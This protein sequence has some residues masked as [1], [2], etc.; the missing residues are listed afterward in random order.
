[1]R[2]IWNFVWLVIDS[3]L[4]TNNFKWPDRFCVSIVTRLENCLDESDSKG[5]RLWPWASAENFPGKAKP[6]FR[7]SFFRLRT[8]QCKWTFTKRLTTPQRKFPVKARAPLAFREMVLRWSC[9]R[10]CEKVVLFVVLCSFYWIGISSNTLLLWTA[11][12]WLWIGLEL[13]T[14]AFAVLTLVCACWN[15]L[16]KI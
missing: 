14:T 4:K 1:M 2:K 5:L 13:S 7:L 9:I 8:M 3:S 10:V 16:L 15:S 12:N 11:N 6:T